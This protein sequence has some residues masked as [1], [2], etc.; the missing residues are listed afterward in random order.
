M[1]KLFIIL[2]VV[3]STHAWAQHHAHPYAG[4]EARD[5]KALSAQEQ[6]GWL[7]GQGM[8]L[9]KTAELNSHP[10]P[11]HVLE[12]AGALDLTASQQEQ[13]RAL[14]HRHKAEVRALGAELVGAERRL[15]SLFR[16][17]RATPADVNELTRQIGELQGR[18]RASHLTTHLEQTRMLRPAQ[19][20]TYDR[21]RGYTR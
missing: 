12:H 15:D 2:A 13:S 9:A 19:V 8:G 21:L 10:G 7:E 1:T 3:A 18:I 14:M 6:Q 20:A 17:R 16:S 11:M 4:E 5:I